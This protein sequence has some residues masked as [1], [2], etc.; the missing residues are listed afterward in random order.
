[1]IYR[2]VIRS[3]LDYGS[4][5]YGT[6]ANTHLNSLESVQ[7]VCL[8]LVLGAFRTSPAISL[9]AEA[10][11]PP[12]LIRRQVLLSNYAIKIASMPQHPTFNV[13]YKSTFKAT[14]TI[15]PL[16]HQVTELFEKIKLNNAIQQLDTSSVCTASTPPWLFNSSLVN[17]DLS[18]YEKKIN[19]PSFF[20]SQ[21]KLLIEKFDSP[22]T[23]FTD[24]SK[25]EKTTGLGYVD[26]QNQ[27]E[28][29]M[30][31]SPF[32]SIFTAEMLAIL[33]ALRYVG[34]LHSPAPQTY[35]IF[36]DSLSSLRTLL[37]SPTKHPFSIQIHDL[38]HK[39]TM[40]THTVKIAWIPGH[41]GIQG[42]ESA[43]KAANEA[44]SLPTI[45]PHLLTQQDLKK[46]S[47]RTLTEFWH[48]SFNNDRFRHPN[49]T[50]NKNRKPEVQMARLRI[51]HTNFSHSYLLTHE[52]QPS[53]HF[54]NSAP[55]TVN[56]VL[57]DCPQL[58]RTRSPIYAA[59][60]LKKQTNRNPLTVDEPTV[61]SAILHFF[62]TIKLKI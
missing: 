51:G 31:L 58:Q 28:R 7:N 39:I 2:S 55:L 8:R 61:A 32:C 48:N 49:T 22:I 45:T 44:C 9:C 40:N 19:Q 24:G 15:K 12:L 21:Y 41:V 42:N 18:V 60:D 43:D 34:N 30:K 50:H 38:A 53:C 59:M 23:I 62:K 17:L 14:K 46:F 52:Q 20:A 25:H 35:L 36:S 54:C 4:I 13:L 16:A 33:E 11:E 5:V 56:H 3:T 6:A 57:L 29:I 10:D 26:V 27:T 37:F 47:K 1:M